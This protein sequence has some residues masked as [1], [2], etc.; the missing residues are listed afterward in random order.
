MNNCQTIK[1]R[2]VSTRFN[3]KWRSRSITQRQAAL[4]W[5]TA[6][7]PQS[8]TSVWMVISTTR[9]APSTRR[10]LPPHPAAR[11]C[12]KNCSNSSSSQ[13]LTRRRTTRMKFLS[14]SRSPIKIFRWVPNW[15]I[16]NQNTALNIVAFAIL[17][18]RKCSSSTRT[19]WWA[20]PNSECLPHWQKKWK[21]AS[22]TV[23]TCRLTRAERAS[24]STTAGTSKSIRSPDQSPI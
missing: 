10:S 1:Q 13:I 3:T 4:W 17:S 8:P 24:F 11:L 6:C 20:M 19:N 12:R 5:A 7:Q 2:Q 16:I 18:F 23:F 21:T 15:L 14:A 9:T 22:I